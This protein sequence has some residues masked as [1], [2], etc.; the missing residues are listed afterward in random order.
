MSGLK[1]SDTSTVAGFELYQSEHKIIY[2][3]INKRIPIKV[4]Y[5]K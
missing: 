2:E 3:T 4:R 1:P 5:T